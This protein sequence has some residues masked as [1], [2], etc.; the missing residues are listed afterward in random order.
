MASVLREGVGAPVD[1]PER[2]RLRGCAGEGPGTASTRGS[3][4]VGAGVTSSWEEQQRSDDQAPSHNAPFVVNSVA[5]L[6]WRR[7]TLVAHGA[8]LAVFEAGSEE[9]GAP[10]AVLLHGLGHWSEAAWEAL[11]PRLDGGTRYIA[12]DLPGFGASER[13]HAAYDLPYFRAVLDDAIARLAPERFSCVGHSLGGFLAADLAARD[14]ARVARLALIAPAGFGQTLR[15]LVYGLA[16]ALAPRIATRRPP[17]RLVA[18]IVRRAV[19]DPRVLEPSVVAHAI[20]LFE[21]P[22]VRDAFA[23]VYAQ[24]LATFAGAKARRAHF[25]HYTGPVL[26]AWGARDRYLP[27]TA[28]SVV[29]RVYPQAQTLVLERSAHLPMIEEPEPLA[30]A[31][32][33]FLIR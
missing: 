24:A 10:V 30:A 19:A 16:C 8:R 32:R 21:E 26:C 29:R 3:S 31:L 9:R 2:E 14:P 23:A 27:V 6:A 18:R 33:V 12:I 11:V 15:H 4:G 7:R 20:A 28:L 1:A 5:P 13:P 17:R 25:G 22:A